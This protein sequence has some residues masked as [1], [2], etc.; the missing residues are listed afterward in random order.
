MTRNSAMLAAMNTNV[1]TYYLE[2]ISPVELCPSCAEVDGLHIQQ[3]EVPSPEFNRFLYTTVGGDWYWIDR[4]IW[5]YHRWYEYLSRPE[6]ET[7]VGYSHGTPAGYFELEK[8]AGDNVEVAYFGLLPQ[9]IG[10]GIG[11]RL[12]SAAVERAWTM[13]AMRVWV[14]TCSLDGPNA[15]VN[16]RARGFRLYKE[17]TVRVTLPDK[18]PGSWSGPG[19][20]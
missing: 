13:G 1:T 12:L 18:K 17:E 7:W 5:S 10:R 14:H 15:L 11:G 9:F 6:V 20:R 8:Q 2:M 4:L 16:Y 19:I 3:V